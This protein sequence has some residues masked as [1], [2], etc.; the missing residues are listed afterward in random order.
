MRHM[1][2]LLSGTARA[3]DRISGLLPVLWPCNVVTYMRR[4]ISFDVKSGVTEML[5]NRIMIPN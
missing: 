4:G 1:R 3:D 5:H 2:K